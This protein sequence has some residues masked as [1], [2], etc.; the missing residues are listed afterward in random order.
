MSAIYP[1]LVTPAFMELNK[2]RVQR[3]LL[4]YASYVV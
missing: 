2:L 4:P 1:R 3:G